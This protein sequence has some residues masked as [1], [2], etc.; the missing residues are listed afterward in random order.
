MIRHPGDWTVICCTIPR[1]DPI[2]AVKFHDACNILGAEGQVFP[3]TEPFIHEPITWLDE[4]NL[5]AY[6]HIVTHG[7]LGEYGHNQH[8]DVHRHIV[9]KYGKKKLTFFGH[10]PSNLKLCAEGAHR[11]EL[12]EFEA[13]RKLKALKAYDHIHPYNG[14][15]IPKWQALHERYIETGEVNFNVETFDG[16]EP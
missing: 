12:S 15:D 10:K 7:A 13:A 14:R 8:K 1:A 11:I 3:Q 5:D 2:R 16:A 4:I 6:D 9:R